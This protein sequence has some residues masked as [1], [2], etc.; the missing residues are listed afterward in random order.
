MMDSFL[1]VCLLAMPSPS[2]RLRSAILIPVLGLAS[3][4]PCPAQLPMSPGA[5]PSV[6]SHLGMAY[7]ALKQ[8]RYEV[9]A[10]EFREALKQDPSLVMRARFPLAVCL[11]EMHQPQDARRELEAVRQEA[12]DHPNI[13][14]Y[15]GRLDLDE[16]KFSAAVRNL[17]KAAIKPPFPDTAYY[18]GFAYFK[19]GN[20]ASAEKWLQKAA[21]LT[22]D[23]PR[24][25]YQ[26]ALVYKGQGKSEAAS[27]AFAASEKLR[28]SAAEESRLK[29]EC[30][31]K[32]EQGLRQEAHAVCRQLYDPGDA[33]KLTALGT[34]YA[35]HG[36]LEAAL[37][38]LQRAA[39]LDSQSPQTQYNLA[40]AYFQ[41]NRL[42]EA[43]APL[44]RV[45]QRWP[46]LFQ[47]NALYGAVL[48]KMG[49]ARGAYQALSRAH[50]L[51]PEDRATE[52]L[53]FLV[54]LAVAGKSHAAGDTVESLRYLKEAARLKPVEPEPHRRMANL[55]SQTNQPE[56]ARAEQKEAERLAEA[57]GKL[58]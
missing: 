7:D 19:L 5:P 8:E 42:E 31:R 53:L 27:K 52:D 6:E 4:L 56:Q 37:P 55:Y 23:D 30:A 35:Q 13:R 57:L 28:R 3:F 16:R 33:K 18:L 17:S 29:S 41:L 26:L 12:G 2:P 20:L 43:R 40:L 47:L 11:F 44:A 22:P 48:E 45:L 24:A 54:L 14:Y 49:D 36:D 46:D 50:R 34:I 38:P 15:L 32:L 51:N 9:A 21:A 10:A 25:S 1:S 58:K 39:E